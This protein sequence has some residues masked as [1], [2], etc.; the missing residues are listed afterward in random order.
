MALSVGRIICYIV[1]HS[2]DGRIPGN[3]EWAKAGLTP[4]LLREFSVTSQAVMAKVEV[5]TQ[6]N[7][8]AQF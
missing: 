3:E 8:R 7:G 4:V 6:N 2:F 1:V 5:A